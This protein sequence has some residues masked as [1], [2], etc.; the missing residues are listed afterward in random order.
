MPE[1]APSS[2]LHDSQCVN[3]PLCFKFKPSDE[4]LVD[5][6]LIPKNVSPSKKNENKSPSTRFNIEDE[7]VYGIEPWNLNWEP[8][9]YLEDNERD[10]FVKTKK[11]ST[12]KGICRK[13]VKGYTWKNTDGKKPI[14]GGKASKTILRFE[15]EAGFPKVF[16]KGWVIHE[17]AL[18][19]SNV[20]SNETKNFTPSVIRQLKLV[21]NEIQDHLTKEEE[22][23][24]SN[25]HV[26]RY[27]MR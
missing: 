17:Y 8:K 24:L 25:H 6:Y 7:D 23:A 21:L 18:Q 26:A 20:E 1:F 9:I 12:D 19:E 22:H 16:E 5:G 10:Y 13:S 3:V 14:C 27:I 15:A 4:E 11:S 2:S